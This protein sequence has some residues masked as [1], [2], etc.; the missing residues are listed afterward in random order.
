MWN[1]AFG[2][3]QQIGQQLAAKA[4]ELAD[5]VGLDE[6]LVSCAVRCLD[7]LQSPPPC[8]AAAACRRLLAVPFEAAPPLLIRPAPPL[9]HCRTSCC[10]RRR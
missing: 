10:K 7:R 8:P 3:L 1:Q 9:L 4:Q 5:E 6:G 2:S